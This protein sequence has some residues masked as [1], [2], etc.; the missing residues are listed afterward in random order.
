MTKHIQWNG[1]LQ[2]GYDIL[3]VRADVCLLTKVGYIIM[4]SDKGRCLD[5][6]LKPKSVTVTNQVLYFGSMDELR[7]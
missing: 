4:T 7:L 6:N 1:T 3:K 2:E 5:A